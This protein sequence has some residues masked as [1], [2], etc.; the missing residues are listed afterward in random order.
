MLLSVLMSVR[1]S[2]CPMR[3]A[4]K[5]CF[6]ITNGTLI[7]NFMLE[8]ESTGQLECTVDMSRRTPDGRA[9]TYCFAARYFV[10]YVLYMYL[11][12]FYVAKLR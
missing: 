7:G 12:V 9:G 10:S 4:Q 1:L 11:S 5:R 2:D 3:R 8:V 6:V